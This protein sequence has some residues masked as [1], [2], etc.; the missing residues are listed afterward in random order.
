MVGPAG[1]TVYHGALEC[2]GTLSFLETV[3]GVHSFQETATRGRGCP[4]GTLRLTPLADGTLKFNFFWNEGDI[5]DGV[6]ILN[7]VDACP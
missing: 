2:T 4:S 6:G 1:D 7:R 3:D 5:P